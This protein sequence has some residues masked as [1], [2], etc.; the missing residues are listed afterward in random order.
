ME[1]GGWSETYL[2]LSH[3]H[4]QKTQLY[5]KLAW[6]TGGRGADLRPIS[7]STIIINTFY[8]IVKVI[9]DGILRPNS[10]SFIIITTIN[11]FIVMNNFTETT[12]S[13]R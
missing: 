4:E 7:T 9:V 6:I 13:N 10:M 1:K 2:Q 5:T 12:R 11:Y 3:E 8:V